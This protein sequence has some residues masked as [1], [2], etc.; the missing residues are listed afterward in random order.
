MSIWDWLLVGFA[1]LWF[2]M[3]LDRALNRIMA[4]L[5]QVQGQLTRLEDE[6]SALKQDWPPR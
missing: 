4:M 5:E 3:A 6:L 2:A 1:V